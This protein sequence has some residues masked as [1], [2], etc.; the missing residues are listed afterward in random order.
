M[1]NINREKIAFSKEKV[2][3]IKNILIDIKQSI[4]NKTARVEFGR[5]GIPLV[6]NSIGVF[7]NSKE[8]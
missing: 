2:I 6:L 5:M 8:V 3:N 7:L 1:I 4:R